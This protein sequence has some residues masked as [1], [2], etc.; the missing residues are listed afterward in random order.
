MQP[1]TE[2][3]DRSIGPGHLFGLLLADPGIGAGRRNSKQIEDVVADVVDAD[4]DED[5]PGDS[6]GPLLDNT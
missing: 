4:R 2:M 1:L 6:P 3:R 5:D